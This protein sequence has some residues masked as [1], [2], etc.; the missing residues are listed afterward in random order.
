MITYKEREEDRQR[1]LRAGVD[2]FL[3][4]GSFQDATFLR[5]VEN[6]FGAP[7]LMG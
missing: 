4:N 3:T 2:V 5:E 6:L 7:H 1:G